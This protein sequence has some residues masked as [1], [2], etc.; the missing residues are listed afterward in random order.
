[1]FER[2]LERRGIASRAQGAERGWQQQI[3]E[4]GEIGGN[5]E[6]QEAKKRPKPL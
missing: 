6:S 4:I 3:G 5:L 2:A 1:M